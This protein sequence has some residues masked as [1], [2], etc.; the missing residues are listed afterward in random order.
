M[1]TSNV[2]N[3]LANVLRPV[4]TY[5]P[6]NA[7]FEATLDFSNIGTYYGDAIDVQTLSF[8]D[9]NNNVYVGTS[10]G[11]TSG[12]LGGANNVALGYAAANSIV[13]VSNSVYIGSNTS[14][15]I[16][17][18]S[19][20]VAI[21]AS[22]TGGGISNV[23]LGNDTG[24]SG[25]SNVFVGAS[26]TGTGSNMI[27]IGTGIAGG[28]TNNLFRL[29]SNY[30]YGDT[31]NKW[32]GIGEPTASSSNVKLDV[33]GIIQSSGGLAS[34]SGTIASAGIGSTSTIGTLKKGVILVTAQDT[35]NAIHYQ[36]IQVFCPDPTNGTS[37]TAMT[38]VV[39]LGQVTI[40]FQLGGSN[41]QI[42]N[43]TAVRNISWSITYFPIP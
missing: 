17:N 41:I 34:T 24:G 28:S 36:S 1:S 42:S 18:A 2:Q 40:A 23:F 35:A 27:L 8:G 33:S 11:R 14:A 10:S 13:N 26:N 5:N 30:L 43:A 15:G 9:S 37:T 16:S 4:Y 29:G 20:V 39:Q 7:V 38:N 31:S 21:G 3:L 25:T 32:L 22:S 12:D 19:N 6:T